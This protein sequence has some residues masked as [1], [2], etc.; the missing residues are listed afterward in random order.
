MLH[1]LR[2]VRVHC[3]IALYKIF[4][5][6]FY[7]ILFIRLKSNQ[8]NGGSNSYLNEN[9]VKENARGLVLFK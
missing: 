7:N 8:V 1:L 5:L 2:I 9:L 6:R 3:Q 4:K